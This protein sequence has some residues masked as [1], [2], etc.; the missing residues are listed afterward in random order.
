MTS[1]WGIAWAGAILWALLTTVAATFPATSAARV[2][3]ACNDA[4]N[5]ASFSFDDQGLR[6][7]LS[8]GY[9]DA[10]AAGDQIGY[11]FKGVQ[12][13]VDVAGGGSCGNSD[14]NWT[15]LLVTLGDRDDSA[16]LDAIRPKIG[17]GTPDPLPEFVGVELDAGAGNDTLRGHKGDD[18]FAGGRGN[19]RIDIAGGGADLAFCG[20]G[21]KDVVILRGPDQAF[22]CEKEIAG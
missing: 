22:D 2:G 12:N 16:R 17:G 14:A 8:I 11:R 7:R 10:P 19:D 1:K 5:S 20:P 21:K 15:G 6:V 18:T 13:G 9:S 3:A 4:T